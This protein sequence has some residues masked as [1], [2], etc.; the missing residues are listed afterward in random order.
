MKAIHDQ[1]FASLVQ[2]L[3]GQPIAQV[4]PL[5]NGLRAALD[6]PKP[7]AEDM[8]RTAN[9]ARVQA[10]KAQLADLQQPAPNGKAEA[11]PVDPPAEP[12]ATQPEA[13]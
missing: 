2:Y 6:V 4:E 7:V 9:A 10:L 8:I 1:L 11:P 3:G 13:N 12:K 5:V